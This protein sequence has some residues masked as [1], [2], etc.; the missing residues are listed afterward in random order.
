MAEV[1]AYY[2]GLVGEI[3]GLQKELERTE[4]RGQ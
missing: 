1:D 3:K 2:E 4:D